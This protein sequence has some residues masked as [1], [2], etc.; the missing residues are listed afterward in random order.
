MLG[1]TSIE[2]VAAEFQRVDRLLS[3]MRAFLQLPQTRPLAEQLNEAGQLIEGMLNS[4][5][6]LCRF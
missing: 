1:S 3:E 5:F 2:P 6:V 4:A